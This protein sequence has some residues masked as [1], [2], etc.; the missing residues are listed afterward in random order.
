METITFECETITPMFLAGANGKTPEL[1]AASIKGALRF[2]WRAMNGH[3][4]IDELRKK[5]AAIFGGSGE[6]QG[7]S[8]VIV[9]VE[10][11]D[12]INEFKKDDKFL[13]QSYPIEY[14]GKIR[15]VN[16]IDYLAYSTL[17]WNKGKKQ[18]E[19]ERKYIKA[20]FRFNIRF[21]IM[22][23]NTNIINEIK[24]SFYLI[25]YLGGLGAKSRNGFGR[26]KIINPKPELNN[27]RE[28][29]INK[30]KKKANYTAFSKDTTLYRLKKEYETW[31][32][33]LVNL[34]SIYLNARISL[35]NV[36]KRSYIAAPIGRQSSLERHNKPYFLTLIKVKEK[37]IKGYILS[38]PYNYCQGNREL[39][40]K[41]SLSEYN[42]VI[43]E[44]NTFLES[45]MKVII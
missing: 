15:K 2:W 44:F 5:E 7:R 10:E 17:K 32:E 13:N 12:D 41:V 11:K 31:D 35:G 27:I 9:R 42:S 3:L 6:G 4:S 23:K 39:S 37:K 26:F 16:I 33:A 40:Q 1:R 20:G 36:H 29:I 19:F 30:D 25:A 43:N 21:E 34:G 22:L 45:N 38:I 14:Q 24:K 18:Y 28:L 8:K